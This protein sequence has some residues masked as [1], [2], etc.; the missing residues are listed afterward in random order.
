MNEM[1]IDP[2]EKC[3]ENPCVVMVQ[4]D[5]QSLD[6]VMQMYPEA[7]HELDSLRIPLRM[8]AQCFVVFSLDIVIRAG[9]LLRFQELGIIKEA[10]TEESKAKVWDVKDIF[11]SGDEEDEG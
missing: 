5:P 11:P 8:C 2:C 10:V 7:E 4:A 9:D 6:H 3:G 1:D